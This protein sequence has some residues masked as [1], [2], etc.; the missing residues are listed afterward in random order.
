LLVHKDQGDLH[1]TI[2]RMS[3]SDKLNSGMTNAG[4]KYKKLYL[5]S[6]LKYQRGGASPSKS[7]PRIRW[8]PG[9]AAPLL[10]GCQGNR[11]LCVWSS[12]AA[13]CLPTH[14]QFAP[15][16]SPSGVT[17]TL[18][19]HTCK[20]SCLHLFTMPTVPPPAP[21]A[22]PSFPPASCQLGLLLHVIGNPKEQALSPLGVALV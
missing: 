19:G 22:S 4:A 10:A 14:L 12:P 2:V 1:F 6:R 7:Y 17:C 5:P 15:E 9:E 3:L 18:A 16:C 8:Q 21:T 11:E 13:L 20:D